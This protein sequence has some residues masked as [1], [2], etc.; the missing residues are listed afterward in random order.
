MK[1]H[2]Y[3]G[4]SIVQKLIWATHSLQNKCSIG[5]F[6][7]SSEK[8]QN[9]NFNDWGGTGLQKCRIWIDLYLC[10]QGGL[11]DYFFP[12]DYTVIEIITWGKRGKQ[13]AIAAPELHY[14]I[15]IGGKEGMNCSFSPKW[16]GSK[17]NMG[18]EY[19]FHH[20]T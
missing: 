6:Q 15:V 18:L 11:Y 2:N 5:V 17:T 9:H 10:V 7:G 16:M 14:H 1:Q 8:R 4:L 13:K 3:C 19:T 12:L 20:L